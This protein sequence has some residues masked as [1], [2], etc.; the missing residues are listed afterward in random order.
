MVAKI[1]ISIV[2]TVLTEYN[3]LHIV[4]MMFKMQLEYTGEEK[5]ESGCTGWCCIYSMVNHCC[6]I[7]IMAACLNISSI[8]H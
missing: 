4:V 5:N 1:L 8:R 6:Q 7:D 3:D 2:S